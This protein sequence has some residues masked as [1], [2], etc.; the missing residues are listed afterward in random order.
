[1][2][3]GKAEEVSSLPALLT[4][5]QALPQA[6]R[7]TEVAERMRSHRPILE[8]DTVLSRLDTSL[9]HAYLIGSSL[10]VVLFACIAL[11]ATGHQA[12]AGPFLARVSL[13]RLT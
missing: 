3:V 6:L 11:K 2:Y 9:C 1:M 8:V 13:Q 4:H 5:G 7:T 12:C 10:V